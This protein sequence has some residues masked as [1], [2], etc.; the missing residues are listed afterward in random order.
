MIDIYTYSDVVVLGNG[1]YP[2][3]QLPLDIIGN[4]RVMV[5]CDGA[6]NAYLDTP[7]RFDVIVGD[8]DS[9][10]QSIRNAYVDK[11]VIDHDQETNDQTKAVKYL[12]ERGHADIS[13]VG[14]SGRR[15][16]HLFGNVSLLVDY[17]KNGINA[18]IYTDH[19]VF[20]PLC[21]D[22][23][24]ACRCGQQMS[25][26]NFGCTRLSA[27]GLQYAI[28]PFVSMWEGTLNRVVKEKVSFS[29]DSYYMI[30]IAY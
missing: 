16:D 4:H 3:A 22:A 15:E 20:I 30:Y 26:F 24:V 12:S 8:G 25:I 11:I 14:A 13:I 1:D 2:T 23:E 19:G 27:E 7:R 6:A 18:R 29:A 21:G 5:A 9:V 10:S 28:R 17:L